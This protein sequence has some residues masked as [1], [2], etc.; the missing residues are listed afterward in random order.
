[1]F[2]HTDKKTLRASPRILSVLCVKKNI[3]H[4]NASGTDFARKR[5]IQPRHGM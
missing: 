5:A 1:M 3:N 4:S 2:I